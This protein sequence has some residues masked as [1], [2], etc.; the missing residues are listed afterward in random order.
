MAD[1][2]RIRI[3]RNELNASTGRYEPIYVYVLDRGLKAFEYRRRRNPHRGAPPE[4]SIR[5][6][7]HAG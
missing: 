3:L 4:E 1:K 6:A 5:R 7:A 2:P